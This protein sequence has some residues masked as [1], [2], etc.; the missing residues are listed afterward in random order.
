MIPFQ[1]D[2][3]CQ[4]YADRKYGARYATIFAGTIN[5]DVKNDTISVR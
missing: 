3:K 5:A 2:K 1:S 4:E